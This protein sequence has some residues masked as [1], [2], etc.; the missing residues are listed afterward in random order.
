M[1]E[2]VLAEAFGALVLRVWSRLPRIRRMTHHPICAQTEF[3]DKKEFSR[4]ERVSR[5]LGGGHPV[6]TTASRH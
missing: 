2:L 3:A 5:A 6:G 4:R 1:A